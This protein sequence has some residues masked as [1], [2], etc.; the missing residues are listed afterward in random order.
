MFSRLSRPAQLVCVIRKQFST[1]NKA[2]SQPKEARVA[3]LGA[4]GGIGQPLGLLLKQSPLISHLNLYDIAHTPGVAADLSHIETRAKVAG[5]LGEDQL[6][7]CLKGANVVIIPAGVPRKPGMTRDD[8]F[9]TNA[10]IVRDLVDA[11]AEVCPK[12]MIGVITNP[13]SVVT[14]SEV[15][16]KRGVYDPKRVFGSDN[17]GR[18]SI[19][20]IHCRGKGPGCLESE[21]AGDWGHSGITIIPLISQCTPPVSFPQKIGL[22]IYLACARC[23]LFAFSVVQQSP[24]VFLNPKPEREKLTV[25]I[26]NA[27]HRGGRRQGWCKAK[28][29]ATPVLLG[30]EGIEKNLGM[31]KLIDFEVNLLKAAM[32]ELL[33]N[34]KKGEEFVDKTYKK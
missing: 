6:K 11:C 5:F 10:G 23:F 13:V 3:L 22:Q 12:A 4:S 32:P 30:K 2:Y 21:R 1:S 14:P 15:L 31:G 9:N 17:T 18:G 16:K 19:K 25:R 28:Y 26:Q 20:Y 34:I 29:F 27:G 33:A 24:S 8:L 7:Q